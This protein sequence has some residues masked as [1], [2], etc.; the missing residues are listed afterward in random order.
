MPLDVESLMR[1]CSEEL[2]P[3]TIAA[4]IQAVEGSVISPA[5]FT[6][7]TDNCRS[8]DPEITYIK[9]SDDTVIIDTS[10]T[11]GKL[12]AEMDIFSDWCRKNGL[13]LNASK[14]KEL[15]IDFRRGQQ[16]ITTLKVDSQAIERVEEYKYLG[17][18]IDQKLTFKRN[19]EIIFSKCQQRLF[20]L[21]KLRKL[22]V[23]QSTLLAFYRCFIESIITFNITAWFGALSKINVNPLT[24]IIRMCSKI[25]GLDLEP[26]SS[27][28]SRRTQIKG[29]QI[30]SDP[31]HTHYTTSTAPYPQAADRSLPFRTQRATSSFVSTSIILINACS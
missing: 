27:I 19:N 25:I 23:H 8:S 7:Y 11:E 24:K 31:T 30:A 15:V 18:T 14:T 10:N 20:F 2:P 4:A 28:H 9:Y 17:T 26:L 12:Q 21:R 13:D 6:L 16:T 29:L 3:N 22:Q 5:L 1:E